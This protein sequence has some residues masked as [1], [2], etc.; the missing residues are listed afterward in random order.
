[1]NYPQCLAYLDRLGDEVLTMKFGLETTRTLLDALG[2]PHKKIPCVLIA[3]TNGKGSV[4]RFLNS[5]F[6]ESGIR[7]ALYTSPHLIRPEE[8]IC[9]GTQCIEPPVF[10]HYLTL[11]VQ[12]IEPLRFPCHPTYF[13]TLTATAF[14]YFSEQQVE[15]AFLEVGMGGRLDSTNVVDPILSIL[16]PIGLDHQK[17]LG[18]NLEAIASE[19][20][21]ILRNGKPALL[22]PQLP[23]VQG[24]IAKEAA[25]KR[26]QLIELDANE[27]VCLGSDQGKYRFRFHG[28]D[29]QL[30]LY[31][32]Q[33][34]VNAALAIRAAEILGEA[35]FS[36]S[37]EGI[38]KGVEET[39]WM[40]RLQKVAEKPTVFLDGAHNRDAAQ[41]LAGFISE[42]TEEPRSL[43]FATMGDKE[44]GKIL[45]ILEP[46]F[47]RVYLTRIQSRRAARVEELKQILPRGIPV[48]DPFDA[49]Q[50]AL[51]S[52]ATV[53]VAGSFYLVG[54]I[55]KRLSADT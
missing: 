27:I 50:R 43:V 42:H 11:L 21:A 55:L 35:G 34:L 51:Q 4:A 36:I 26:A 9:L 15:I 52:A 23:E 10:A 20:A 6:S 53:I 5:I 19:K 46:Y 12:T 30:G 8:R 16:T 49:Y 22:A 14:L 24:V 29:C 31:G 38:E 45:E 7:N 41:N 3:G 54:E 17:F 40:G 25:K 13:E 18:D 2:N 37:S 39:C 33:Q 28:L 47:D 48:S 44:I 1:M 32:R